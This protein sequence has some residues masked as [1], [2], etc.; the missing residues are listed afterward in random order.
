M[1]KGTGHEQKYCRYIH[2]TRKI[3]N[4]LD[5]AASHFVQRP[6]WFWKERDSLGVLKRADSLLLGRD[7]G[8]LT[9]TNRRLLLQGGSYR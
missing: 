2:T 5:T 9:D 4:G 6:L 7:G 1:T 3:Q 8:R